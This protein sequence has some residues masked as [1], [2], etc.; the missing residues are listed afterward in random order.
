MKKRLEELLITLPSFTWLIFF[1]LIPT[2]LLFVLAFQPQ[3]GEETW[4]ASLLF[5]FFRPEY[6][7]IIARTLFL[8]L[9]TSIVS[10]LLALP[11]GYF[12]AQI[13]KRWRNLFLFIFIVPFWISFLIRILAWKTVL[14]P[15]GYLKHFLF[16]LGLVSEETTLL[17]NSGAVFLVMVYTFLPFAIFPIYAASERFPF[18]L[19]EAALDLG[20][21]RFTA[22][23]R[24]FVPGIRKGIL[25]AALLVFVPAVGTYVIPDLVGGAYSDMLGNKIVAK[26]LVERNL[27]LASALSALLGFLI[28]SF[29][30]PVLVLS[31]GKSKSS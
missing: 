20:A 21:S 31:R 22:F 17:Y 25:A 11:V 15:E 30:L 2:T 9:L 4:S 8:S 1:F 14:H 19:I 16:Y 6:G 5:H 7:P 18:Q 10:V 3:P 29:A 28:V 12:L 23:W 13:K 27:P 24:V 26:A